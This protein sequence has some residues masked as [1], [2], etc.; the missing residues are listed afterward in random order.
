[1]QNNRHAS[2]MP[3][4]SAGLLLY[5]FPDGG[6]PFDNSHK[7]AHYRHPASI[8]TRNSRENFEWVLEHFRVQLDEYKIRYKRDHDSTKY[9]NWIQSNYPS[10]SF[11]NTGLTPFA[12]CFGPFKEELDRT[13]PD[14]IQAYQKFYI[15]DKFTFSRWPSLE[16]I[17]PFWPEKSEKFV[18]KNFKNGQYAKR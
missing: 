12:R 18:D 2:R 13:E 1:M 3:L 9:L 7:R 5:A 4:E 17:A 8:F 6:T 15:L 14:T 16:K 10:I 11:P